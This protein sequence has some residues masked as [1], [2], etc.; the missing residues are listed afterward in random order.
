M[1]PVIDNL[2]LS[3]KETYEFLG[4]VSVSIY[5]HKVLKLFRPS[6]LIFYE[7]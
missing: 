6:N 1:E 3:R 5:V 7:I 2:H 4:E